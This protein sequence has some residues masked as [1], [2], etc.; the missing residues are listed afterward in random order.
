MCDKKGKVDIEV[1]FKTDGDSTSID[2][3]DNVYT[4]IN[5]FTMMTVARTAKGVS[6][7]RNIPV[8]GPYNIIHSRILCGGRQ[9]DPP[10]DALKLFLTRY[11]LKI[12]QA[13]YTRCK[14]GETSAKVKVESGEGPFRYRIFERDSL[15]FETV[16]PNMEITAHLNTGS[17]NLKVQ[18]T[19]T[20]CNANPAKEAKLTRANDHTGI[21]SMIQGNANVCAGT[22]LK[23]SA[24]KN[25]AGGTY[26]WMKNGTVLSTA[27]NLT[28]QQASAAD[29]GEYSFSMIFE[30]CP[31]SFSEK[32]NVNVTVVPPPATK[33]ARACLSSPAFSLSKYA[34]NTDGHNILT[35]YDSSKQKLSAAPTVTPGSAATYTYYVTQ[36]D[37]AKGCESD[38]A[39]VTVVI[40]NLPS[41][42]NPDDI[43]VCGGPG[44]PSPRLIISNAGNGLSYDLYGSAS[45]GS[46]IASAVSAND[47]VRIETQSLVEGNTYYIET[48]VRDG[49][50]SNSRTPVKIT[51]KK[52]F[53][54]GNSKLCFGDQLALTADYAGTGRI[55]WTKP[56]NSVFVGSA[57]TV[58]N[59]TG[60]EA[61]KYELKIATGQGC[62]ITEQ[63]SVAV[64]RP[65]PPVPEKPAYLFR[66]NEASAPLKAAATQG[67]TLK[68][69]APDGTLVLNPS[70]APEQSP[71]P[72]TDVIGTFTYNVL[73]DSAGCESAPVSVLATVGEVPDSVAAQ[74]IRICIA[75]KPS[76]RI[77][78]T[79][80]NYTY[81]VYRENALIA[82]GKGN[83]NT[84]L[85]TSNVPILK[86]TVLTVTV[87]TALDIP[88]SETSKNYI[89]FNNLIDS[90]NTSVW[91]CHGS[92]GKLSAATIENAA[93]IWRLPD[94]RT[95]A[96]Q[97]AEIFGAMTSDAGLHTLSVALPGCATVEQTINLKVEKPQAPDIPVAE[98]HYCLD[99][100]AAN[101]EAIALVGFRL[102]WFDSTDV[103]IIGAPVPSTSVGGTAEYSVRQVSLTN[104]KCFS[105][106]ATVSVV[107]DSIPSPVY[108]DPIHIC[109]GDG[110]MSI[111]TVPDSRTGCAYRL[112]PAATGGQPIAEAT[113]EDGHDARIEIRE[114]LDSATTY[115]LEIENRSGCR[116]PER[117]PVD[118]SYIAAYL[119]PDMLPSYTVDEYYSFRLNT[120]L[121]NAEFNLAEGL[122]PSGMKISSDGDIHGV[123]YS[124]EK[125]ATFTVAARGAGCLLRKE[126]TL[127][128]NM[129]VPKMF[130]PN[131]DMINDVFMPHNKVTIFNRHGL[132]I[133][134]GDSGW[135]GA[136]SGKPMPEDVYFYILDYE[137]EDGRS[138]QLTGHVTL[139]R[140]F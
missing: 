75:E 26:K 106:K 42:V 113:G 80:S 69:Y 134:E 63:I 92:D 52:T 91:I 14:P 47:T 76:V 29:A 99:D 38:Y 83:G 74:D 12:T 133:F 93:Y 128:G 58:P 85:L 111:V 6:L 60:A 130:S 123:T 21:V 50:V 108:L 119:S 90:A 44:I 77:D 109:S 36:T 17:D 139:I 70:G 49:C 98:L 25:P 105:D 2:L 9:I 104:D 7:L 37:A 138:V 96:E 124:S 30:S 24:K 115:Y 102:E 18:V 86:N 114:Q 121:P 127:R 118:I 43:F 68:W 67:N 64:T 41:A 16:D 137:D 23:L 46:K 82:Q 66:V 40:D 61:G 8:G 78:N 59:A 15:I 45:G 1:L 122:L 32:F 126:Y 88:S 62:A 87:A 34:S 27:D 125:P 79:T 3:S 28:V 135:D 94:G 97:T 53:I 107:T 11:D 20:Q 35:W 129:H 65:A 110:M 22:P 55:S 101:L 10:V 95:V 31:T 72:P 136:R 73:Q 103:Q 54:L 132:K 100:S 81:R 140:N 5:P 131:G 51:V 117:T 57:L 4:L 89:A 71:L 56:D 116:A 39:T 120:N 33:S 19:D 84:I 48:G 112:Y 13:V